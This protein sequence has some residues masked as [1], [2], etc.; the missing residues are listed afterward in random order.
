[1]IERHRHLMTPLNQKETFKRLMGYAKTHWK[2]LAIA[3]LLLLGGTASELIGPILIQI[4]IDD[5][6]T[7]R[8]FPQNELVMLGLLYIV[9]HLGAAGMNYVQM[10]FFQKVSL[11]IIQSLRI[12]IFAKVQS[13]GL[14]F[15]DQFPAGGLIS[16]ITNDTEQVKELYISVLGTFIQNIVFLLGIFVAMFYLNPQLALF[17]LVLIPLIIGLMLLYK[18]FSSRYYARMSEKLSELNARLNES[19]QGMAVI[20]IFRQERRMLREFKAVNE[21]HH[22]AW[23]KSIKLDGLLLR[24]A[25]DFISIAAL[26]FILSYFGITSFDQPVELGVLYAF[27]NYLDRFFEPVNQIMQRLSVFQQAMISAGRVFRLM[28][29]DEPSPGQKGTGSPVINQGNIIFENV[30]FSYDGHEDVL[31]NVSFTIHEGETLAIVGHTGS[32]KSSIIN[33]LLRFYPLERGEIYIDGVALSR[34][35]NKELREKIGLVLQDPFLFAGDISSNIRLY[36][37]RLTDA[38]VQKAAEFVRAD[39]FI[40]NLTG[41]YAHPVGER[42]TTFSGGQRQLIAFARTMAKAPKIL[43]LDEATASIDT[44]TE[45]DIQHALENMRKDRTTIAIAH[46][47]STIKH[48]DKILVMHQGEIVEQ[49][50]HETL[51]AEQGL[52]EKMYR[53]Q[54]A[55]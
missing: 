48:A 16:R 21:D 13:L 25:V 51:I 32:G 27:V 45:E 8:E 49:G 11:E 29:H 54:K 3:L 41:G 17:C 47:L 43:V 14:S 42:G 4:F 55:Y 6:L 35:N 24:P 46:R 22:Q 36:D 39:R 34:Y 20:Q 12:D 15:F 23:L 30:S 19:I 9:L 18:R 2:K 40:E 37:Q 1:M 28:D 50:T 52:Y 44:E 5:Y 26:I 33:L 53:L 10:L 7:P 38:D 31:K